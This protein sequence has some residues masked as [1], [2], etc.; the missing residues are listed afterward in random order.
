[1]KVWSNLPLWIFTVVCA[2][3]CAASISLQSTVHR[4][5]QLRVGTPFTGLWSGEGAVT[6]WLRQRSAM[7]LAPCAADTPCGTRVVP[8]CTPPCPLDLTATP[9]CLELGEGYYIRP[10]WSMPHCTALSR[11]VVVEA[12][13]LVIK[14]LPPLVTVCL[15]DG[16]TWRGIPATFTSGQIHIHM[17]MGA[18]LHNLHPIR[19]EMTRN[20]TLC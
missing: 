1:M 17:L 20:T 3:L 4:W 13:T 15:A 5:I 18:W 16:N 8:V 11:V 7:S 2:L 9:H 10:P 12:A 14:Q 19:A 6:I